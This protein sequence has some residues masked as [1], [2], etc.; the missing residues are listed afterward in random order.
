M[1]DKLFMKLNEK[2][3]ILEMSGRQFAL[4]GGEEIRI[5]IRNSAGLMN[6]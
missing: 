6:K 3:R 2:Q 5:V 1:Q 4:I